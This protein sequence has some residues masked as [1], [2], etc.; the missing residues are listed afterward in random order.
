MW[1]FVCLFVCLLACLLACVV[2][3]ACLLVWLVAPAI[4]E[5]GDPKLHVFAAPG[6][7]KSYYY[8]G[9]PLQK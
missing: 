5:W 7:M 6:F 3:F 1:L 8:G 4:L 2:V 9:V